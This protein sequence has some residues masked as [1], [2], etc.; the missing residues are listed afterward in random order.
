MRNGWRRLRI[1]WNTSVI[2]KTETISSSSELTVF[3]KTHLT[4]QTVRQPAGNDIPAVEVDTYEQ[5]IE[6]I[7][8]EMRQLVY[9][10]MA[11]HELLNTKQG[12]KNWLDYI[13]ELEIKRKYSILT[14][15][16]LSKTH[17]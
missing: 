4:I 16:N 8:A 3:L 17:P 1:E 14:L 5:V 13:H 6:K 9:R 7:K 11:M 2:K 15:M 10:T 12:T